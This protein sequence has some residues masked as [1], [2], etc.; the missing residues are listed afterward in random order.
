MRRSRGNR[1]GDPY[2]ARLEAAGEILRQR[3]LLVVQGGSSRL[4][5]L[6]VDDLH[7]RVL[8]GRGLLIHL[9]V[10]NLVTETAAW[11]SAWTRDGKIPEFLSGVSRGVLFLNDLESAPL[12]LTRAL[13]R[14]AVYRVREESGIFAVVF[15][16]DSSDILK[17]SIPSTFLRKI[18]WRLSLSPGLVFSFL[19]Q[20][21]PVVYRRSVTLTSA[22]AARNTAGIPGLASECRFRP[23][24]RPPLLRVLE[25]S[26]VAKR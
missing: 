2:V 8:G 6:V 3:R 14:H 4:R 24:L 19:R 17:D 26:M 15:G 21:S 25:T 7:A 18:T 13:V 5:E 1:S 9:A 10:G 20:P 22:G 11:L 12:T 23:L 16:C